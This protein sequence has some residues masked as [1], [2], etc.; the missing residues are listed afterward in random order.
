MTH[1]NPRLLIA[2]V[3]WWKMKAPPQWTEDEHILQPHVGCRGRE[4]FNLAD[5]V[6]DYLKSRKK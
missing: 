6:V 2:A 5:A 4:E 1:D 3:Q